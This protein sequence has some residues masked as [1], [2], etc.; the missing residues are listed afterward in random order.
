MQGPACYDG[1]SARL[2]ERAGF[3]FGF[4]SG[5]SVSAARLGAP[6]T[7]LLSYGE[8]VDAARCV[9]EA[10][11]R[12]PIIGDGDTGYGN[13][14]NVRRTVGGYAA[15][16]LAGVLIEDQQWPK[17]CGHVQG[18]RVVPR[19][20]AVAR[21]RAACDARCAAVWGQCGAGR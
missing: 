7:G 11:P 15:A 16:G 13:A 19:G 8:M 9:A 14:L 5:F 20:E 18:K 17:Q 12:L 4:M 2:I 21:I 10:A 3:D 1:L 6:D